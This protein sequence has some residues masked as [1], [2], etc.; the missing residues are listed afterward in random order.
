MNARNAAIHTESRLAGFGKLRVWTDQ[1]PVFYSQKPDSSH[2][3]HRI[4]LLASSEIPRA[5]GQKRY[6]SP[7]FTLGMFVLIGLGILASVLDPTGI[8]TSNGHLIKLESL[9]GINL[10]FLMVGLGMVL[11]G[12]I[13]RLVAIATL[14]KNFSGALRIREGHTLIKTG[15]YHWIRHPAYLGA[16]ILFLGIPVM[17]SSVLGFLV[18]FLLVPYLLHRIKLEERMLI[19]R[20]GPEYET[21]MRSSKR[22]I[23]FVY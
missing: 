10:A 23:P 13:I 12:G 4:A 8:A 17:L 22:L 16:I 7:L 2:F 5:M 1:P 20:F 19:G 3:V 6:E 21:Y 18:T 15:I 9:S 14:K 11:L